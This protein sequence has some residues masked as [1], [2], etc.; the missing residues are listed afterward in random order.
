MSILENYSSYLDKALDQGLSKND[1]ISERDRLF[2]QQVLPQLK[3]RKANATDIANAKERWIN[4]TNVQLKEYKFLPQDGKNDSSAEKDRERIKAYREKQKGNNASW[5]ANSLKTSAQTM[6]NAIGQGAAGSIESAS[7]WYNDTFNDNEKGTI[8]DRVANRSK[9]V[10]DDFNQSQSTFQSNIAEGKNGYAAKLALGATQSIPAMM[11]PFGAA[12]ATA[13]GLGSIPALAKAAPYVAF[14]VG[15]V[16]GHTQNYGD[17]RSNTEQN[18]Q[19]DFP[20]IESISHIPEF[21]QN[22]EINVQSGMSREQAKKQARLDTIDQLSEQAATKYGKVMTALDFIAPSG[23]VLG[24]GI[25]RAVPKSKMADFLLG[26]AAVNQTLVREGL[27]EGVKSSIKLPSKTA[28]KEAAKLIAKQGIE[29]GLQGGIGSYG[30]QEVPASVGGTPVNWKQVG[31]SALDEGIIGAVMG[32]GMQV[33][34]GQAPHQEA[35]TIAKQIRNETNQLRQDEAKARQV[36]SVAM[37]NGHAPSIDEAQKDLDLINTR[38]IDLKNSYE[39][40]GISAPYF[41]DTLAQKANQQQNVENTQDTEPELKQESPETQAINPDSIVDVPNKQNNQS[42]INQS[43]ITQNVMEAVSNG[44]LNIDQ[45]Y[46]IQQNPLLGQIFSFAYNNDIASAQSIIQQNVSNGSITLDQAESLSKSVMDFAKPENINKNSQDESLP[47]GNSE[48]SPLIENTEQTVQLQQPEKPTIASIVNKHL[49]MQQPELNDFGMV[50]DNSNIDTGDSATLSNF[51]TNEPFSPTESN[52]YNAKTG[53]FTKIADDQ[54]FVSPIPQS[55]LFSSQNKAKNFIKDNGLKD[56]HSIYETKSGGF[57]VEP[58][59]DNENS[60]LNLSS[61]NQNHETEQAQEN[62]HAQSNHAIQEPISSDTER[63]NKG[64]QSQ[65]KQGNNSGNFEQQLNLDEKQDN[66]V[67]KSVDDE[68]IQLVEFSNKTKANE[69]IRKNNLATTHQAYDVDGIYQVKPIKNKPKDDVQI[70][71]EVKPITYPEEN[72]DFAKAIIHAHFNDQTQKPKLINNEVAKGRPRHEVLKEVSKIIDGVSNSIKSNNTV[73]TLTDTIAQQPLVK[74]D[75]INFQENDIDNR[76]QER[77]NTIPKIGVNN[78]VDTNKNTNNVPREVQYNPHHPKNE[79]KTVE[80][81][82]LDIGRDSD[83]QPFAN[84]PSATTALKRKGLT[85]THEVVEIKPKQYVLRKKSNETDQDIDKNAHGS[86]PMDKVA[87]AFSHAHLS[88]KNTA[89]S[90]KNNF[91]KFIKDQVNS[92]DGKVETEAQQK[93]LDEAISYLEDKYINEWLPPLLNAASQTVSSSVAGR[94]NFNKKQADSRGS[95]LDKAFKDFESKVSLYSEYAYREVLGARTQEQIQRD[96]ASEKESNT[97]KIQT[98]QDKI[99]NTAH[100]ESSGNVLQKRPSNKYIDDPENAKKMTMQEWKNLH[101]DYKSVIDGVRHTLALVDGATSLVPVLITDEK[102]STQSKNTGADIKSTEV[103]TKTFDVIRDNFKNIYKDLDSGYDGLKID[104]VKNS[105]NDLMGKYDELEAEYSSKTKK[106]LLDTLHP[107]YQSRYKTEN[108]PYIVQK[109]VENEFKKFLFLNDGVLTYSFGDNRSIPQIIGDLINDAT[110]EQ[111]DQYLEKRRKENKEYEKELEAR[112][113]GIDDPKTLDDFSRIN[114]IKGFKNFK[115]FYRSLSLQQQALFDELRSQKANEKRLQEVERNKA[116][117]EASRPSNAIDS[118]VSATL[119]AGKH[120]KSG[121]DIWTV[122]LN[123]KVESDIFSEY[124]ATAKNLG[125]YY[126]SYRGNGAIA[127]FVFNNES[128]ANEFLNEISNKT[129]EN[130]IDAHENIPVDPDAEVDTF[131]TDVKKHA[132]KLRDKANSII[133]RGNDVLS[134]N[135]KE[136]THKRAADAARMHEKANK[137]IL[138]GETL[139]RIANGIENGTIKYLSRISAATQLRSIESILQRASYDQQR[140]NNAKERI[141]DANTIAFTEFPQYKTWIDHFQSVIKDLR[142]IKPSLANRL[143]SAIEIQQKRNYSKWLNQK[144]DSGIENYINVTARKSDD[145]M[146]AIFKTSISKAETL[147]K[148]LNVKSGKN[149]FETYKIKNGEYAVISSYQEAIEKNQWQP[150]REDQYL[151]LSNDF[152]REIYTALKKHQSKNPKYSINWQFEWIHNEVSR[153]EKLGIY[154]P[155]SFRSML[156]EYLSHRSKEKGVDPIKQLERSMIGR[157]NDGLDFFPTPRNVVEE[158]IN[159]ADIRP[160]MKV[161]EPSAGMGHIADVLKD[162]GVNPDV[163]EISVNRRELLD[164]KGYN[165]VGTDFLEFNTDDH[166]DRIIM[167]PPF[168]DRRDAE[169]IYHAYDLLNDD[170]VLVAIAG[171]GVFNGSDA[172]AKQFQE[173][174]KQTNAEVINLDA[175]TFNDPSLPVTTGVKARIIKIDKADSADK[176]FSRSLDNIESNSDKNTGSTPEQLENVLSNHFGVDTIQKLKKQGTL[177]IVPSYKEKGIE[178]FEHGGKVTLVADHI[179]ESNV[180]AVFLHELGGHVG[181]QG[182][183]HKSAYNSLMNDFNRMVD[184]GNEIAIAAKKRAESEVNTDTQKAEYLPYLITEAQ[185]SSNQ[186]NINAVQRFI[187]RIVSAVKAW[188]FD[189]IGI[190]LKLNENDILALANRMVKEIANFNMYEKNTGSL[191]QDTQEIRYSRSDNLETDPRKWGK[192]K[193][194]QVFNDVGNTVFAKAALLKAEQA[195][196][197]SKRTTSLFNTMLHKALSNKDFKKTFDLVQEKINHVTFDSSASMDVA[198]DILTQLESGSDYVKEAKRVGGQLA[199][200]VGLR[201]KTKYQKDLEMVG[202]HLFEN[203]LSDDPKVFT[204]AELRKSGYTPDQI[205]LYKQARNAI[206]TS[207]DSFAKTTISKIYKHLGAPTNEILEL[208]GKNLSL[209]AHVDEI[210]KRIDLMSKSDPSLDSAS[211]TAKKSIDSVVARLEQ[212]KNE[213]YVP[214]M[215]FGKFFMR[216][217]DPSTGEVAY[218]QHFESEAERNM[219]VR[220]YNVPTGYKMEVGQTNEL[221]NKL[222]A[223]VSPETVAL[224]AKVAGIPMDNTQEAYIKHAMRDNH[225]LKRLLRRQGIKGFDTDFKRVLASFVLSNARYGANQLYNPAIDESIIEIK[226]NAYAED[227]IRLRDYALDTQEE[228]AGIK[229]FAFVWYMG[230]SLMFG[231]VNLTQPFIQTIPYLMQYSKKWGTTPSAFIKGM[232][233][234]WGKDIPSK[235]SE[236]YE[237][238]RKEGHLDPQNTW[239]LQG[240]ERGKSGLGASTW[241]LISHA[242][243]FFSQA[244]ETINRRATLFAALDVAEEMGQAKLEKFGFKNPYDFAIRTIQETQGIYNKGNRP[245]LA[246]GNVGSLLMMYKQFMIAYIEQ[247]VRMQRNGLWGGE[248]DEFKKKMAGLVGFGISKSVLLALGILWSLSGGTGLPFARDILDTIETAGGMVGKPLNTERE[249][250]IALHNALGD[251][252]GE[253]ATTVLLDGWVNL[254]PVIDLKGRMG[255]GDLIPATGYFNPS[256]PEYRKSDELAG[257]GGAIGG[258]LGKA[259]DAADYAKYGNYGQAATQLAPKFVTSAIQGGQ[260]AITGDYRNMKTGVKTN[261]ASVLDGIIKF[262]DAQPAR[263]AKEGRI[264]G[265]EAKDSAIIQYQNSRYKERFMSALESGEP[266]QVKKVQDEIQEFNDSDPRY[267]ITFN[268]K[269]AMKKF[270]QENMSWQ[271]KR[272]NKKGLGWMDDYNPYLTESE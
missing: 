129:E 102:G 223:G 117:R 159:L 205:A 219:F 209:D 71:N 179:T 96:H 34:S 151:N 180:I 77:G 3:Q 200:S 234:W 187:K 119:Y 132:E 145:N 238:A 104:D 27:N 270:A 218:R 26:G 90:F 239:M 257:L 61:D 98:E 69:Y 73:Q 243:G 89:I 50:F 217:I 216:I 59:L 168:S 18:L 186:A 33:V 198:P 255:M 224:F 150:T 250:Q 201:D 10:K 184:A 165:T 143:D 140:E 84:K 101:K 189:R 258:L 146:P 153:M 41:I 52:S 106:E 245:R 67:T 252:L 105:Y 235:Y 246:R 190:P 120:T 249:I 92:A 130:N 14:G 80:N 29:E 44:S 125:G 122:S 75:E 221:E 97:K 30:S 144:D 4:K 87:K 197:L 7:R 222:F 164:L 28:A 114:E 11:L 244:S 230:A 32:S 193:Q 237:Q 116:L 196:V 242:S 6:A 22:V 56:T 39:Q 271:E 158:M 86:F 166:Y 156:R 64:H 53:Q 38:A 82:D 172:K 9:S 110:Q 62:V 99:L 126:S 167:N 206:D 175:G 128:S 25:K 137:E 5:V 58:K 78:A 174:L 162:Y 199:H 267:P 157:S 115:D 155:A 20:T 47:R 19:K 36:L 108:K 8:A 94:S 95:Q 265:L 232:K 191:N 91:D 272:K 213:G 254:N 203:T 229:N 79:Q 16:A 226:D 57:V 74:K 112:K 138:I 1:V 123:D 81:G 65:I 118:T 177:K 70:G 231:L 202:M 171:E 264:R 149:S 136:N 225:A 147:V 241:Q 269:S 228:V 154:D 109:L 88:P 83:N 185:N 60:Q 152:G 268:Q 260:A 142:T 248:D 195:K 266:E 72:S 35:K 76:N 210:Q 253:T 227:A 40:Y 160:E 148:K 37:Q 204:D 100:K 45:A 251:T 259:S 139:N 63:E 49:P 17:V 23:A 236:Y 54:E 261:D 93:A 188:A 183:L 163:I 262:V 121:H 107:F 263:I 24:S 68:D 13:T 12:K 173:W 233:S 2:E 134:Q 48:N 256:T 111:L 131:D 135:R 247:M 169:H 103:E 215:R 212:L 55:K 178:G 141:I 194:K 240:L 46:A 51:E 113:S 211:E 208:T 176:R 31:Q 192:L 181:L 66:I 85:N 127:G 207:L 161:L 42:Q 133:N 220:D 43:T 15:G 21:E 170:G 214:L 124:R 182:L